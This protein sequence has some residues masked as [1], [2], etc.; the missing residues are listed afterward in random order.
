MNTNNKKRLAILVALSVPA[1]A[2]G[3]DATVVVPQ[4]SSAEV[5]VQSSAAPI[6]TPAVPEAQSVVVPAVVDSGSAENNQAVIPADS[7]AVITDTTLAATA[8]SAKPKDTLSVDFPDEDIRSILRNV[9]DLFE[10]NIVIPDSLQGKT[11]IKLR[12]VTWRQIFSVILTPVNYTFME[13]GNIIKVVTLDSL[14]M[15]PVNTEVYILNYARAEE[16]LSSILPLVDSAAGGRVLVDKRINA[17]IVSERNS[18]L[19]KINP[20]L[21]ALDRVTEQVMIET[22]FINIDNTDVKNFGVQ[23]ETAQG[24]LAGRLP[25]GS[26]APN[27]FNSTYAGAG[28]KDAKYTDN[29]NYTTSVLSNFQLKAALNVLQTKGSTRV[30]SNPTVVTLNNT[31]S[32]INVGEEFPIP[33]YT[34]N[35]EQG[36]F[37]VSGFEYKPIG[38][39]LKV[40]P[41]INNER[42]I[43]LTIEPEVSRRAGVSDFNGASIPIISVSKTKTQVSLKDGH[44][45]AIGGL[46]RDETLGDQN[47]I[48]VLGSIP[49]LGRLFRNDIKDNKRTNLLIFITAKIVSADS[50]TPQDIFDP[51]Q[52]KDA[53]LKRSDIGGYR[54]TADPFLPEIDPKS[55]DDKK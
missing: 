37:E 28:G 49:V 17:L 43:K 7:S 31:E 12:D 41:Q 18:K 40:T 16:V 11:S 42:F 50:A 32:F 47:K 5:A 21:K 52:I 55:K 13:E 38:I 19:V 15:E 29:F 2:I 45:L 51:R 20:V 44:T 48:P 39:I 3:Q 33:S 35:S 9:A 22:K 34:Y 14:A 1:L 10:L 23:W 54:E 25:N 53:M 6:E 46:I 4:V 8:E 27:L 24:S 30:V 26:D 36:R